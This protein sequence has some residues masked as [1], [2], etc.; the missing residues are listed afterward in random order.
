MGSGRTAGY[1]SLE[2]LKQKSWL[3]D[4]NAHKGEE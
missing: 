3:I 4:H 2:I 1:S